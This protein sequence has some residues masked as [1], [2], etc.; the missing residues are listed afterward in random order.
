MKL[1]IPYP[2]PALHM[3]AFILLAVALFPLCISAQ[4]KVFKAGAATSNITPP[5][6]MT[7]VG[8]FAPQPISTRV[9]DELHVRCLAL[10]DGT[11]KL[12]FAAASD[13][14]LA[15]LKPTPEMIAWAESVLAKP[16]DAV[17]AHR[18]EQ[19]YAQRVLSM[20]APKPETIQAYLQAFR[21]GQLGITSIPFEVFTETGLEIKEKS[22]FKYTFTIELASGSNGYLPTPRQHD[23]GGYETWIGT[24]RVEREA[25]VKITDKILE[26][27]KSVHAAP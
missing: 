13:L 3:K 23:L 11:T 4:E 26:L 22:P 12:V 2:L 1:A 17:P 18:L 6:G 7:I 25:S 16:K 20:R 10:D 19:P 27:L 14:E 24:S 15:V 21:I 9:N 8:N 5:L